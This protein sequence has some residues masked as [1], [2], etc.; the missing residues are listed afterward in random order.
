[1]YRTIQFI[2]RDLISEAPKKGIAKFSH[3]HILVFLD[4]IIYFL[5]LIIYWA[6]WAIEYEKLDHKKWKMLMYVV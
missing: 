4:M 3:L 5:S 2:S 6:D 1:M